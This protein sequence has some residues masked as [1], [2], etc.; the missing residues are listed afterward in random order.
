MNHSTARSIYMI[1]IDLIGGLER[2]QSLMDHGV[3][4]K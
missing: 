1:I 4:E 2:G 3:D